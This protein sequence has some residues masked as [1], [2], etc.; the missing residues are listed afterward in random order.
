MVRS[1]KPYAVHPASNRFGLRATR[2]G[3]RSEDA[4]PNESVNR[5]QRFP[6]TINSA[7]HGRRAWWRAPVSH[8]SSQVAVR[9]R[10]GSSTRRALSSTSTVPYARPRSPTTTSGTGC[11]NTAQSPIDTI[12][13]PPR[14]G[15]SAST[16]SIPASRSPAPKR[17]K[18][19][20]SPRVEIKRE[21]PT[22]TMGSNFASSVSP[23][24]S[25]TLVS[26][27]KVK[28]ERGISPEL[29]SN[30]QLNTSGSKRYAPLPLECR[31]S[32]PNHAAAR[33]AW[34]RKEQEALRRLG[35][36]VVRSF[37]REDGM[38][39]DWEAIDSEPTDTAA[40]IE[41]A[42]LLN[43]AALRDPPVLSAER[44]ISPPTSASQSTKRCQLEAPVD[45]PSVKDPGAEASRIRG[46]SSIPSADGRRHGQIQTTHLDTGDS[47]SVH[48][49]TPI[50]CF[51]EGGLRDTASHVALLP[52]SS[53]PHPR[54]PMHHQTTSNSLLH[55]PPTS[56][57][58]TRASSSQS[59]RLLHGHSSS[60]QSFSSPP[61]SQTALNT[62]HHILQ[63]KRQISRS[64]SSTGPPALSPSPSC[65]KLY[66]ASKEPQP[67]SSP[68]KKRPAESYAD[69][70]A[71]ALNESARMSQERSGRASASSTPLRVYKKR[72]LLGDGTNL[73]PRNEPRR[74]E[75]VRDSLSPT[76]HSSPPIAVLSHDTGSP[77]GSPLT[78]LT[79]SVS[80]DELDLSYPPSPKP[81]ILD[82]NSHHPS[83]EALT[84]SE[85]PRPVEP[86]E[87]VAGASSLL[88]IKRLPSEEK[89]EM[90]SAGLRYLARYCRTFDTDR[91]ALREA[92]APD[93][94]FS[95]P[96][97]NLRAKGR[98]GIL[99]A[100]TT[101]GHDFLC[102]ERKAKYEV[103]FLPGIG[104]LLAGAQDEEAGYSM[105]FVLQPG[106]HEDREPELEQDTEQWP[107]VAI[108][109]QIAFRE[110]C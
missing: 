83:A 98:D 44:T 48:T 59:T 10:P 70:V 24:S 37:I 90:E 16:P 108:M 82:T 96:S 2:S 8:R 102:S 95:C 69:V 103:S 36:R 58:R 12:P 74:R 68:S 1:W 86:S 80:G 14:P 105:N 109:H 40:V 43:D 46:P 32:H 18:L 81:P 21:I 45:L 19:E 25:E 29:C 42:L 101:L 60:P 61:P 72:R 35:L 97:R 63:L 13:R 23:V 5:R 4:Q 85:P 53:S 73:V 56:Q 20:G 65:R 89:D 22:E 84:D 110:G 34:A 64:S 76:G 91:R 87:P 51:S 33:S 30:P 78:E 28:V 107:L 79:P 71:A 99:D 93:A 75:R 106:D 17:Q 57:M 49:P 88:N 55:P 26:N 67:N 77:P 66:P 41:R 15:H 52:F 104:T 31:K 3:P 27:P 9:G 94:T 7:T 39:I 47:A 92:Y 100:L 62:L 11:P 50:D 54:S 6:P 38:V